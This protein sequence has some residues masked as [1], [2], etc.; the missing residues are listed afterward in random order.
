MSDRFR[1]ENPVKKFRKWSVDTKISSTEKKYFELI[2]IGWTNK[3][4]VE[5]E[6]IYVD[7]DMCCCSSFKSKKTIDISCLLDYCDESGCG[8]WGQSGQESLT[9]SSPGK[10]KGRDGGSGFP[11]LALW[12]YI[13][14]ILTSTFQSS[15]IFAVVLKFWRFKVL[16]ISRFWRRVH[17]VYICELLKQCVQ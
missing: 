2:S 10:C 1:P 15:I 7:T 16:K 9:H 4:F 8:R 17:F 6:F 3:T 12:P 14:N 11:H 13:D 5:S